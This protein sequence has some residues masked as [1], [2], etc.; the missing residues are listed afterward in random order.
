[1]IHLASF[2]CNVVVFF[3]RIKTNQLQYSKSKKACKKKQKGLK[4]M[5]IIRIISCNEKRKKLN[6]IMGEN[7]LLENLQK[8]QHSLRQVTKHKIWCSISKPYMY[9]SQNLDLCYL[10]KNQIRYTVFLP[11][12]FRSCSMVKKKGTIVKKPF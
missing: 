7:K 3:Y 5:G 10:M 4:R 11:F 12:L 1:M 6:L 8:I 9:T 2:F